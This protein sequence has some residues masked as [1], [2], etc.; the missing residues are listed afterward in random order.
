MRFLLDTDI[1]SFALRGQ[2][3]VADELRRRSPS[4]VCTSSVVAGEL[5]LGV[6]RR[7]SRKLRRELEG[8]YSGLEVLPYDL[9]AARRYGRL[10][11]VLLDEGVPI[12]VEDTMVAAHALSLGLTLVTHNR[13][14]FE[15]VKGLRVEDWF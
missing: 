12:G 11:A 7:G 5:E 9:E 13:K 6:A 15:R 10:A 4:E 3:G 14:H 8:L 1:I 2:G